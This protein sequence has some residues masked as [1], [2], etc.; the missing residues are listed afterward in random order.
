MTVFLFYYY[1]IELLWLLQ[2]KSCVL[3]SE[4]ESRNVASIGTLLGQFMLSCK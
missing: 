4:H 2:K 3:L 1:M